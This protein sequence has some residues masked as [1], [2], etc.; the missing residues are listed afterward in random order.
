[1]TLAAGAVAAG[2]AGLYALTNAFKPELVIDREPHKLED[3]NTENGWK[4]APLD[5]DLTAELAYKYYPEGSCMYATIKSIIS[6]LAEKFGEPYISFPVDLFKYGHGG[7][8][9]YGSICGSLNGTAALIGLFVTDSSV[10]DKMIL[11]I[12]RWY[13]QTPL[14]EFMPE[15]PSNDYNPVSSISNSILCHTAN[16]NWC[17]AS[18]FKI[19]SNERKEKCKR[20]T[21]DV[22]K[23]VTTALNELATGT[24]TSNVITD[25]TANTCL[26]CHGGT[27]K[28]N[29]TAAQMS[30]TPCH[31]ES[32]G[33]RLFA[34]IHYK[35]MKE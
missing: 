20:M 12:F 11:D 5:P 19:T 25:E 27:G 4:Y 3:K 23:K 28:V 10:R 22:V 8:G 24:Y 2:G 13:E 7:V 17:K 14:P 30:C 33:H 1:M 6:Q 21:G 9:G 35:L 32:I 29:N 34:D 15:S 18:G 16:T 26:S 31:S